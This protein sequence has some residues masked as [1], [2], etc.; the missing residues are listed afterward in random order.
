MIICSIPKGKAKS[1]SGQ[2]IPPVTIV[3]KEITSW[4]MTFADRDKY[5]SVQA[6]Y[7][8]KTLAEKV[9]VTAGDGDTV[10]NLRHTYDTPELAMQNAKSKLKRLRRGTGTVNLTLPGNNPI[11]RRGQD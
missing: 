5:G 8:D 1:V 4:S 3:K 2:L 7:N 11:Y 6:E 9:K 10:F